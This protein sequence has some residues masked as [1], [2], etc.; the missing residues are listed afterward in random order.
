MIDEGGNY[1][2]PLMPGLRIHLLLVITQQRPYRM[3]CSVL[4]LAYELA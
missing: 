4:D 1:P 2:P 3:R